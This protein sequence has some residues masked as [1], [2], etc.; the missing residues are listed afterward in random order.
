M[1]SSLSLDA[2]TMRALGYRT[3]DML[4]ERIT[5]PPG[6]VVS[7]ATPEELRA[8]LAASPPENPAAFDDILHDLERDV[9]PFVARLSHPGYLAFIPGEG[10]WPGALGDLIAS[11]LNIDTCW[12]MGASGPSALELVVL[13]WFRQWVGYP[14]QAA[15]VL[16]S[17]GSA[18]NLTA[19]ACAREARIG[20]MDEKRRRLHVRPDALVR[21]ARRTSA[22][23]PA[24]P[25][26][27]DP[28][29]PARPRFASTPSAAPL[30]RTRR[31]AAGPWSWSPTPVPPRQASSIL[32]ASCPSS[33]PST[34]S[35]STSTAPTARSRASRSAGGRHSPAWSSPTRS[36][37][38][39]TSGSTSRSRSAPSSSATV[40]CCA[41]AS[42]STP[43]TSPTR[44]RST[45]R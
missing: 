13:D 2:E 14:E 39:R 4:V 31:D 21:R 28:D 33:A 20:P 10:T 9:L 41:E 15:G 29:R 43:T 6:P 44:R 38:T 24:R 7:A 23:L 18:A 12:W 1:D 17:G 35:G 19:L 34:G 36:R 3:V 25:G 26:A 5:G 8:R 45:S 37:S 11:A 22:R 30:P 32:S 16:V 40:P 42:R 27:R